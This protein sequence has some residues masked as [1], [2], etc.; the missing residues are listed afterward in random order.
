M[1]H[2][3]A[4]VGITGAEPD[5]AA[6]LARSLANNKAGPFLEFQKSFIEGAG[7]KVTNYNQYLFIITIVSDA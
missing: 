1:L 7:V 6:P 3:Y 5:T 2:F 4:C